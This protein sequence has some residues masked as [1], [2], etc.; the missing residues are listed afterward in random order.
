[1]PPGAHAWHVC[2]H[3]AAHAGTECWLLG[4]WQ[5]T[6]GSERTGSDGAGE[7]MYG[8]E[9]EAKRHSMTHEAVEVGRRAGVY[10]CAL[11]DTFIA[12]LH[13][14]RLLYQGLR[15]MQGTQSNTDR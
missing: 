14:C 3:V 9:A 6:F 11:P 12:L 2:M 8:E 1:M 13:A 10:R 5:A 4:C 7:Y 15:A